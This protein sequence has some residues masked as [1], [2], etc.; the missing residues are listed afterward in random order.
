MRTIVTISLKDHVGVQAVLLAPEGP[1]PKMGD[2]LWEWKKGVMEAFLAEHPE[3][4]DAECEELV[5]KGHKRDSLLEQ[6]V[7]NA[8]DYPY[9]M[10]HEQVDPFVAWLIAEKGFEEA[11]STN[12]H[13][14]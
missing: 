1:R 5:R 2:F 4:W 8:P 9:G 7:G 12:F 14:G 3:V 13:V 6:V 11:D 10:Y